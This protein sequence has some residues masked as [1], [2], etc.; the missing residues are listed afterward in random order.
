MGVLVT[1][2]AIVLDET[3]YPG[4][5]DQTTN[6]VISDIT[7]SDYTWTEIQ[8]VGTLTSNFFLETNYTS[9]FKFLRKDSDTNTIYYEYTPDPLE[10]VVKQRQGNI[11]SVATSATLT[12]TAHYSLSG[13]TEILTNKI[14]N[15]VLGNVSIDLD[16]SERELWNISQIVIEVAYQNEIVLIETINV[17]YGTSDEMA[18]LSLNATNITASINDAGLIFSSAGLEITNGALTIYSKE[19]EKVFYVDD[20]TGD[21]F[22]SGTLKTSKGTLG[23]WVIGDEGLYST[24]KISVGLY[25]GNSVFYSS[26]DKEDVD[27]IRF[28]AGKADDTYNFAVTN[29]GTLYASKANIEGAL[30]ATS[31]H[32]KNKFFIGTNESGIIMSGSENGQSY[33]GSALY[34]SGALGYGWKLSEDGSAEFNNITARGKITSSVFEYNKI[35]SIGGNLYIAPTIYLETKSEEI[36]LNS[37]TGQYE[38]TW[39]LPYDNLNSINGRTWKVG[40]II[41]LDG[42]I[43]ID[44][45]SI[46]QLSGI[47][48]LIVATTEKSQQQETEMIAEEER[49]TTI[50]LGFNYSSDIA[51]LK[52]ESGAI[53]VLYGSNGIRYGLYLSASDSGSPYLDVYSNS[54]SENQPIPAARLGNLEGITDASFQEGALS[55]YGLYSSNAYLR[56]KL[57][58]PSAGITNQN[59]ITLNGSPIRIWAGTST[60]SMEDANFIVTEDGSMYARSGLFTGIVRATNS[61]FSGS[62]RAAGILLEEDAGTPEDVN[63]DHFYVAYNEINDS[64]EQILSPLTYLIDINEKGLSIWEGGLQAYSD[65]ASGFNNTKYQNSIYGYLKDGDSPLPYFYL[66]D[67]GTEDT[68]NSRLVAYKGHFLTISQQENSTEYTTYSVILDNGIWF[69]NRVYSSLSPSLIEEDL[70]NSFKRTGISLDNQLLKIIDTEGIQLNSDKTIYFNA[71]SD[72]INSIRS[73]AVFIKGQLN[74]TE[75][76]GQDNFLSLNSQIIKEAKDSEGNSIGIDIVVS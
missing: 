28:W 50:T 11:T 47:D 65:Y 71:T 22:F 39:V 16:T 25:S 63:H 42:E 72:D 56:G 15:N 36:V 33:I 49:Q 70:Y 52:F 4:K 44:N 31:G 5:I 27:P 75:K 57:I 30:I 66:V 17:T 12:V 37:E 6:E 73:E 19:K 61:E 21:V 59:E 1:G 24:D 2:K 20:E 32:I 46:L 69:N 68:L 26:E 64:G 23:G 35:S 74:I 58:L 62:I 9:V 41:K 51:G 48:S 54:I 45:E 40:D 18:K 38:A 3:W 7:L 76:T 13:S 8:N 10:I 14:A 34:S 53:L 43:I 60:E 67:N 55:G 29:K